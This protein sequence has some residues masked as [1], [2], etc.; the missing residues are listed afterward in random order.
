MN[1]KQPIRTIQNRSEVIFGNRSCGIQPCQRHEI[2][3]NSLFAAI[4]IPRDRYFD[5]TYHNHFK[6]LDPVRHR[7]I[8]ISIRRS[9]ILS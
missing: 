2:Y 4:Q 6:S 8:G 3:H 5:H 9:L 1:L 7:Q